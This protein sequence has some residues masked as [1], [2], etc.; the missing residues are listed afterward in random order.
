MVD[1]LLV[2]LLAILGPDFHCPDP[3]P[4]TERNECI[5]DLLNR[6]QYVQTHFW[7]QGRPDGRGELYLRFGEPLSRESGQDYAQ[8]FS[9]GYQRGEPAYKKENVETWTYAD[10][11]VFKLEDDGF[12]NFKLLNP[13]NIVKEARQFVD[14]Q[15]QPVEYTFVY[16]KEKLHC[17]YV[18]TTYYLLDCPDSI[19][20]ALDL[21]LTPQEDSVYFWR[22][23]IQDREG[24]VV[25]R[26][27]SLVRLPASAVESLDSQAV[28]GLDP[29]VMCYRRSDSNSLNLNRAGSDQILA[30][31]D[32]IFLPLQTFSGFTTTAIRYYRVTVEV[33]SL[34]GKRGDVKVSEVKL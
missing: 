22:I 1:T 30:K 32:K 29:P 12:G 4:T 13:L 15:S 21:I 16:D 26:D 5:D 25:F 7:S 27:E 18:I 33:V 6:L 24:Q 17:D 23:A 11:R 19:E 20:L 31:W 10:G 3:N 14:I 28:R 9:I 34:D 2:L 8:T